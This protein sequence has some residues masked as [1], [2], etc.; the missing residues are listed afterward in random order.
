[1]LK[2]QFAKE[3]KKGTGKAIILMKENPDVDFSE[4][5]FQ[6]CIKNL[7]YDPQCSGSREEYLYEMIC[8][9][10][11]K[12]EFED[13]LIERLLDPDLDDWGWVQITGIAKFMALDGNSKARDVI[14]RQFKELMQEGEASFSCAEVIIDIDKLSGLLFVVEMWGRHLKDTGKEEEY[15]FLIKHAEDVVEDID[16]WEYLESRSRNNEHIQY[17]LQAVKNEKFASKNRRN[18]YTPPS[19]MDVMKQIE[20]DKKYHYI[21]VKGMDAADV[22]KLAMDFQKESNEERIEK[23]LK[24]F[25]FVKYPFDHKDILKYTLS[26]NDDV[27]A[28]AIRALA[29]FKNDDV[30]KLIDRNLENEAYLAETFYLLEKNYLPSYIERIEYLLKNEKDPDVGH[31]INMSLEDLTKAFPSKDF[32]KALLIAYKRGYCAMCRERFVEAMIRLQVLP[33]WIVEEAIYDCNMG[34]RNLIKNYR[35]LSKISKEASMLRKYF[36]TIEAKYK[37]PQPMLDEN[38]KELDEKPIVG[39]FIN[40]G[41]TSKTYDEALSSIKKIIQDD[42]ADVVEVDVD[43]DVYFDDLHDD[44]KEVSSESNRQGIWYQ[45]GRVMFTEGD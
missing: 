19:Y 32:S 12:A 21:R 43:E 34:I 27:C 18:K 13:R 2:D 44:I 10:G 15:D 20:S 8:M 6:A 41:I 25:K 22:E 30:R 31:S 35:I 4:E 3:I 14:Y 1:M 36:F 16:P 5:I 9:L 33:D 23:Y 45:S 38:E 26:D 24:I 29:N 17:Y 37:K 42:T 28:E 40:F 39:Y 11:K 7:D